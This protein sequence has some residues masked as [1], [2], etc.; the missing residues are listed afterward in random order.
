MVEEKVK[1]KK[2]GYEIKQIVTGTDTAIGKVGS[3]EAFT[4]QGLLLEII[5]KLDRV[6]KALI[7]K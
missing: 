2:D 4:E 1:E 3:E 5:N 7:G 6:E